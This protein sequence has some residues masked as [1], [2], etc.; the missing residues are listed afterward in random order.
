VPAKF[1]IA[2]SPAWFPVRISASGREMSLVKLDETAYR[3]A[4][5]LDERILALPYEQSACALAIIEAA[6]AALAPRAHY[7]F[8][9]GHAGSTLISRLIGAHAAFFSLREPALL[10]EL[11]LQR[12]AADEASSRL[13][14][15]TLRGVPS[16]EVVLALL[17]RTWRPEQRA[18][19]KATSFVSDLAETVLAGADSPAAIF[20]FTTP[21]AYLRGILAGPNSRVESKTLAPARRRRLLRRLEPEGINGVEWRFEPRSEGEQVAMNWLCE[22]T[23]LHRA[24]QRFGS[25]VRWVD[26]DAF[27]CA[28]GFH[29][30]AI[31]RTLGA[32]PS[33]GEVD[34]LVTAPMMHQYAKAPEHAYDAALRRDVLRSADWEHGAE[35][36]RGLEW[37]NQTAMHYPLV[38]AVLEE[39]VRASAGT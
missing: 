25:Q 2:E 29:L 23:V 14:A 13:G 15:G 7:V 20:M 5:F 36:K 6:A 35:I 17:A 16:L 34:A 21:L 38:R 26:F 3:T 11:A 32:A 19:I 31:L 12:A 39:A 30:E 1:E 28:P 24:A 27:L 22:M 10:R 33:T 9:T 8:H 4:S 18:V 37:L